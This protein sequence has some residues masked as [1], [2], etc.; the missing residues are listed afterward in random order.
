MKNKYFIDNDGILWTIFP[1]GTSNNPLELKIT[2]DT[3]STS[4]RIVNLTSTD[5]FNLEKYSLWNDMSLLVLLYENHSTISSLTYFCNLASFLKSGFKINNFSRDIQ[6][7]KSVSA[8]DF[9]SA[10]PNLFNFDDVYVNHYDEDEEFEI[11]LTLTSSG[12]FSWLFD[13][14]H[15]GR[16]SLES[17]EGFELALFAGVKYPLN[18]Y[19]LNGSVDRLNHF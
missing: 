5:D 10:F 2:T 3:V 16:F 13:F 7:V 19:D 15:Q 14:N 1:D 17:N 8:K 12:R 18:F 11:E 4:E 6:V 9:S